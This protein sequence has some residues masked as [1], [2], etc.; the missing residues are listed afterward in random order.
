[1][2]RP[3]IKGLK[4]HIVRLEVRVEK[5]EENSDAHHKEIQKQRI[6]NTELGA[7]IKLMKHDVRVSIEAIRHYQLQRDT[8]IGFCEAGRRDVVIANNEA[9]KSKT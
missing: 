2:P 3:T 4:E 1:M 8:L 9:N 6:Q 5:A 7:Q